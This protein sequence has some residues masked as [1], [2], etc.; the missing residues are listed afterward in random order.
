MLRDSL[1]FSTEQIGYL[2]DQADGQKTSCF[3]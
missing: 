3:C 2:T 1:A